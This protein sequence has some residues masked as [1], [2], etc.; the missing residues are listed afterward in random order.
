M[1]APPTPATTRVPDPTTPG[2][3]QS[4]LTRTAAL[5]TEPG[6]ATRYSLPSRLPAGPSW[7]VPCR[8]AACVLPPRPTWAPT[9]MHV[10][11]RG[12]P[13][14]PALALVRSCT[15]FVCIAS[16]GGRRRGASFC[17][18][19]PGARSTVCGDASTTVTVELPAATAAYH[20]SDGPGPAPRR[21]HDNGGFR[22]VAGLACCQS[23]PCV[24]RLSLFQSANAKNFRWTEFSGFS[25]SGSLFKMILRTQSENAKAFVPTEQQL[26]VQVLKSS[27]LDYSSA[28]AHTL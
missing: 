22:L 23:L 14:H 28:R 26:Q 11:R 21:M 24:P 19:G 9:P 2:R 5:A 20:P 13:T 15:A 3:A 7:L 8:R 10:P 18:L 4:P 1:H 25:R 12:K 17:W 6:G 16:P 27:E